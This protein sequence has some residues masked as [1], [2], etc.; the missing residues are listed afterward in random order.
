V[1]L[2]FVLRLLLGMSFASV[3]VCTEAWVSEV[4]PDALKTNE[5]RDG[6][7]I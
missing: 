3:W 2:S 6:R 7:S 4:V 5:A 1:A